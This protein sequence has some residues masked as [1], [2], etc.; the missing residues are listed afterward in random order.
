VELKLFDFIIMVR[1]R[2]ESDSYLDFKMD[3]QWA[4]D[5]SDLNETLTIFKL[6]NHIYISAKKSSRS[7]WART[8]DLLQHRLALNAM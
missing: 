8:C 7:D 2:N 5:I 3:S 4:E 6:I 1:L